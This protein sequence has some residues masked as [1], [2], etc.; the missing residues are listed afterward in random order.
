MSQ[1]VRSE[2]DAQREADRLSSRLF[3]PPGVL[4]NAELQVMQ[5]RGVTW[6]YLQPPVGR[7]N[8]DL[9]KMA[10]DGL[11]LPLRAAI[12]KAKREKR[13]VGRENVHVRH[14]GRVRLV[15]LQVV[16]LKNVKEPCYLVLF[17]DAK[18]ASTPNPANGL[19]ARA[20]ISDRSSPRSRKATSRRVAELERELAETRDYLQSIQEQ[21]DASAEEL[22]ASARE[23]QSANEELQSINE[24]LETSKE[25][26]ESTNEEL[27]T[28]NEEM[29]NRNSELNG[30]NSDLNNLHISIN[31]AILVLDR[32]LTIRRF[33][34]QAGK[35]FNLIPGDIGRPISGIRHNL[36]CRDLEAF[37]REMMD[38]AGV[39]EREVQDKAGHWYSLR[40][41]P[42]LT[43]DNKIEG[44]VLVL[45]DI[46][47]LKSSEQAIRESENAWLLCSNSCRLE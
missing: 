33:T 10:H 15:H 2:F 1:G 37:V 24:E 40:A 19:T 29:A 16:P 44:A 35:I 43:L 4:V 36:E 21:H 27:T 41:R 12:N 8:F 47:A 30:L 13:S 3:A 42:Y 38:T 7:A 9:L 14:D 23:G 39:R 45:V 5:F 28:V 26:L 18:K 22:Q 46:A 20:G 11:M 32:D 25:E 17:E 6:P 31:T 34:V